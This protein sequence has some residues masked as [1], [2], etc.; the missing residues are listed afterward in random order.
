M[1]SLESVIFMGHLQV[2]GCATA[3]FVPIVAASFVWGRL[4]VN[5]NLS[6]R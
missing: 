2:Q 3:I 4:C 1:S 6:Q 5:L